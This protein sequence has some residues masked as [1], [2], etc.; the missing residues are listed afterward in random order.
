MSPAKHRFGR[1]FLSGIEGE[2]Q[3]HNGKKTVDDF[4]SGAF[5]PILIAGICNPFGP[6][7]TIFSI[8]RPDET[9]TAWLCEHMLN[10]FQTSF[11]RMLRL[12]GEHVRFTPEGRPCAGVD[13]ALGDFAKVHLAE[14]QAFTPG[15]YHTYC[16]A[17][18]PMATRDT[19]R[20]WMS[21]AETT[22]EDLKDL[23]DDMLSQQYALRCTPSRLHER[24]LNKRKPTMEDAINLA[25]AALS[26]RQQAVER[27]AIIS[28]WDFAQQNAPS[29][30]VATRTEEIKKVFALVAP[31]K[32]DT[33]LSKAR[34][35]SAAGNWAAHWAALSRNIGK[36][37]KCPREKDSLEAWGMFTDG[38]SIQKGARLAAWP[39]IVG[40]MKGKKFSMGQ[41]AVRQ[42]SI[43]AEGRPGVT[44]IFS[45]PAGGSPI[46]RSAMAIF[47]S[48]N[49]GGAL[50]DSI[51]SGRWASL[52]Y[53]YSPHWY[54]SAGD[55][56]FGVEWANRETSDA[57]DLEARR[58]WCVGIEGAIRQVMAEIPAAHIDSLFFDSYAAND[59][60]ELL[61]E[62]QFESLTRT[63]AEDLE[64][65]LAL[66]HPPEPGFWASLFG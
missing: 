38:S 54:A 32:A 23:T 60:L 29:L 48:H 39:E 22:P 55:R 42:P 44:F 47:S 31:T 36:K 50:A 7:L 58:L 17:V 51:E 6:T 8:Q 16:E 19:L 11:H 3:P 45:S 37:G 66:P 65:V 46:A 41:L 13:E 59:R 18:S 52:T 63:K 56:S 61:T 5:T 20:A 27:E 14:G 2:A 43:R 24:R 15:T 9:G 64:K 21:R 40:L 62:R 12:D 53:I 57:A 25:G 26:S 35:G 4:K 28:G 34:P 10:P 1:M 49:L 33:D 30:K